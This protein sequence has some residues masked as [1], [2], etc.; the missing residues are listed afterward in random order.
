MLTHGKT[1]WLVAPGNPR[2]LAEGIR[3]LLESPAL[4]RQLAEA[5]RLAVAEHS[6]EMRA[7]RLKGFLAKLASGLEEIRPTV[8]VRHD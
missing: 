2:A 6:W 1:G 5:A 4:A 7:T 3:T 8:R